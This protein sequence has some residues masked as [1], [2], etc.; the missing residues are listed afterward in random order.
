MVR[1][2]KFITGWKVSLRTWLCHLFRDWRHDFRSEWGEW[3]YRMEMFSFIT[4]CP[5]ISEQGNKLTPHMSHMAFS[6]KLSITIKFN[7]YKSHTKEWHVWYLHL[8][9][10]NS[11]KNIGCGM[12]LWA[13]KNLKGWVSISTWFQF[14][15]IL[16]LFSSSAN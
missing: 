13:I 3:L 7:N 14:M 11:K 12:Y 5:T 16:M 2:N 8:C 1:A 15:Q 4:T 10:F 6:I 9:L